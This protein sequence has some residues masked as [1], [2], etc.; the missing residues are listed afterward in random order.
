M[1]TRDQTTCNSCGRIEQ[2]AQG[3][4]GQRRKCSSCKLTRDTMH[5]RSFAKL[6]INHK[7]P[8]VLAVHVYGFVHNNTP[9]RHAKRMIMFAR[10]LQGKVEAPSSLA[11]LHHALALH[12]TA[13][14]QAQSGMFGR[15]MQ[16]FNRLTDLVIGPG[17]TQAI[18]WCP[19]CHGRGCD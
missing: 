7:L 9:H 8:Q 3:C 11:A 14:H 16:L 6:H 5:Q 13:W 1:G 10:F 15:R 17:T 19:W 2:E 12:N 4:M 18:S